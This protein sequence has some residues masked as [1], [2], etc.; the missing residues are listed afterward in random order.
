[1]STLV[2]AESD[3]RSARVPAVDVHNH[4]GRWLT[5]GTRW[6][7]PDVGELVAC[8]DELGVAT[9]VNLDGRWDRELQDNLERYDRARPGRFAT[10]CQLDWSLLAEPDGPSRL[11]AQ[12]RRSADAGAC[13][14]KV[15][16]DLGMSVRDS[17]GTLVPVDDARLADV[18]D[19]AA[20]LGLPVLVHTADP[21]AFWQPV[22][23]RNERWEELVLHPDW[24]HGSRPVPA[25]GELVSQLER[26]VAA[27]RGT[28]FIAAHLA[29]CAEDLGRV[30]RMLD[31]HPNLVVDLSARAAELG[32]QPRA[33]RTLLTQY[34]DRVLWGTDSFPFDAAEYR[35][36]FRLLETADEHFPYS[37]AP[38]PPQ[39]R[40]AVSGL[41]LPEDVLA[42]V[43]AGNAR[44]IIPALR[45]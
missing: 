12:L 13:G 41:D 34:A 25:H 29:S 45:R 23:G 15:W 27:H 7:A 14:I 39:G 26:L 2:A 9:V 18:W 11:S 33:A 10:F 16:K 37:T 42:Q 36:W 8:M 4:L 1:M 44:R 3:V 20:E 17:A 32:R 5:D 38:V 24:H 40:W 21:V 22:D 6:M 31:A 43:Y 35:I 28:T 30:G 19:T